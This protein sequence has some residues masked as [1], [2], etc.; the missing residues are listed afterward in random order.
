MVGYYSRNLDCAVV[1]G[2]SEAPPNSRA[3]A[4]WFER[5]TRGLQNRLNRLWV[6]KGQYYLG[7]W[8]FHPY[9][10]PSPSS[11]DIE[12]MERIANS[13]LYR[14]PEPVLLIIGGD[15][16]VEWHARAFVFCRG[17]GYQELLRSD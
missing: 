14:C 11:F 6:V 16:A 8:H 12:Q 7:E 15:P 9:A 2:I 13:T 4:T 17:N 3:G 10:W 5:G 1:I